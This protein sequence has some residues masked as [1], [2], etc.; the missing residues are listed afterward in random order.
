MQRDGLLWVDSSPTLDLRSG[1]WDVLRRELK[2]F[3]GGGGK[4]K[5]NLFRRHTSGSEEGHVCFYNVYDLSR[6]T[7]LVASGAS[8]RV[9]RVNVGVVLT[10]SGYER[11][12]PKNSEL[13][14]L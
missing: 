4:K 13:W 12:Q 7:I 5:K 11:S 9:G 10:K 3:P 14:F 8:V 1:E 2:S 6:H